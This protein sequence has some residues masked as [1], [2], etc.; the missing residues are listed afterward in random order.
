MH[1][2]WKVCSAFPKYEISS[3]GN[4]RRRAAVRGKAPVMLKPW[5][6]SMGYSVVRLS[7]DDGTF[8]RCLV[9]RLV[10]R[11]FFGIPD[12]LE[13]DFRFHDLT[14]FVRLRPA[15][16]EENQ[17]NTRGWRDHSSPYKG[18]SWSEARGKWYACIRLKGKT[19]SLGRFDSEI[20]AA[21]VYDD[22]ASTAWGDF[23]FLNFREGPT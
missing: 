5:K 7:D 12:D 19:V 17:Q 8:V 23:A 9:H 13:V 18:V 6:N 22:A 14:D 4:L 11:E 21:R 3:L 10:G 20:E 15:T 1:E 16:R 2:E